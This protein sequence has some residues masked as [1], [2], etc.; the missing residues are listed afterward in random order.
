MRKENVYMTGKVT[1][2]FKKIAK[3][4]SDEYLSSELREQRLKKLEAKKRAIEKRRKQSA[5]DD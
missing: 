5:K 3:R 1:R 2:N 4:G